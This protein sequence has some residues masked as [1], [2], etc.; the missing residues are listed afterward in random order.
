MINAFPSQSTFLI[1]PIRV[2]YYGRFAN[3]RIEGWMDKSRVLAREEM[4]MDAYMP[5]IA[6]I[7]AQLHQ[8][9]PPEDHH[10]SLPSL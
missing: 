3:G 5:G 6:K 10:S 2:R 8:F 4:G 9:K 7:M 1:I